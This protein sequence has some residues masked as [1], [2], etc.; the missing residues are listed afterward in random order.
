MT[1]LAQPFG[2]SLPAISK[3]LKVLERAELVARVPEAGHGSLA[4]WRR[5]PCAMWPIG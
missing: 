2:M 5:N 3:H 1:E 4:S